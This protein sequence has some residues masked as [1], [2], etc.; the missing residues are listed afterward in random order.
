MNGTCFSTE[1]VSPLPWAEAEMFC[2]DNYDGHLA[3]VNN[4]LML[5][6]LLE[7]TYGL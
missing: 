6:F 5:D 3:Q 7:L 4:S 2:V 1:A